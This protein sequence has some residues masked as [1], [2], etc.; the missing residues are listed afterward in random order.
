[1]LVDSPRHHVQSCATSVRELHRDT[2]RALIA[3]SLFFFST[4]TIAQESFRDCPVCP[5]MVKIPPGTFIMGVP[6]GEEERHGVVEANRYRSEPMIEV[7]HPEAFAVGKYEVTV[8]E[9]RAYAE[10]MNHTLADNNGCWNE[11]GRPAKP[12]GNARRDNG[13]N[14]LIAD[15]HWDN[16]G[17]AQTDRHPVVC[18]SWADINAYVSWLSVKAGVKYRLLSESEWEYVARAGT[19]TAWPWGDDPK[20]ACKYGNVA[21]LSREA[22]GFDPS[23]RSTFQCT[24]GYTHTAPVGQFPANPFGLHD[25][26]GNVWEVTDDCFIYDLK[27]TPLDGT[28]VRKRDCIQMAVRGGAYDIF[29]W[30]TRSGYRS[31]FVLMG[32]P[33]YNYEGFRVAR[34]L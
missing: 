9:F 16:P 23:P 28:S 21:D 1:M 10:A 25:L 31:R 6:D 2:M 20:H 29:P 26:L 13:R 27:S 30:F 17:F 7:T 18:V 19:R 32:N 12:T 14:E 11:Y 15:A 24:D 8:G 3:V 34:D 5:E 22:I 33:R 4:L